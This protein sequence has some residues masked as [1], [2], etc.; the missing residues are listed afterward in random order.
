M[1][2]LDFEDDVL[3]FVLKVMQGVNNPS[4]L[5]R[6]HKHR[7]TV[8]EHDLYNYQQFRINWPC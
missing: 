4:R 1:G 3:Y 7:S 5:L 8:V 2:A 6:S